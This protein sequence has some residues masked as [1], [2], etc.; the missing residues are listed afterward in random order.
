MQKSTT[1][2][3]GRMDCCGGGGGRSDLP[4][5]ERAGPPY[6]RLFILYY[7][8]YR[9]L[10]LVV[11]ST[12]PE[13]Q[14]LGGLGNATLKSHLFKTIS[15]QNLRSKH[16]TPKTTWEIYRFFT[17]ASCFAQKPIRCLSNCWDKCWV[18][19]EVCSFHPIKINCSQTP[20]SNRK[21][22]QPGCQSKVIDFHPFYMH[23]E[24]RIII[25]YSAP[26]III[27]TN[28]FQ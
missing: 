16:T 23:S 1:E 2:N 25:Y 14:G 18:N 13:A 24:G 21:N 8:I 26:W 20:N 9:I 11:R 17:Q 6:V 22:A 7:R 12:R 4:A 19:I 15:Y 27:C 10:G 28:Q 5:T 3:R